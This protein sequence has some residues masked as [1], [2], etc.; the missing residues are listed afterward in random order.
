MSLDP[1]IGNGVAWCV[2]ERG[3]GS[4]KDQVAA[5]AGCT[6]IWVMG[7]G[8]HAECCAA[9]GI[10]DLI[11]AFRADV[12][13]A[14]GFVVRPNEISGDPDAIAPV[15][16]TSMLAMALDIYNP[17]IDLVD[18]PAANALSVVTDERL[19]RWGLWQRGAPHARD[20]LR[21]LIIFGRSR[22]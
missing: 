14:E 7:S 12:V 18:Q 5:N 1:G 22:L 10:Y 11:E 15:R 4:A 3:A 9:G 8:W 20:A 17:D 2:F 6:E 19:R 16:I 13:V 21:H